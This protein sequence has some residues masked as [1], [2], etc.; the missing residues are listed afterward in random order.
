[1][2]AT[3]TRPGPAG[4]KSV[5]MFT[6]AA[7]TGQGLSI[8]HTFLSHLQPRHPTRPPR[9]SLEGED[10]LADVRDPVARG[11]AVEGVE[12]GRVVGCANAGGVGSTGVSAGKCSGMGAKEEMGGAQSE[13]RASPEAQVSL[14]ILC[15]NSEG[16]NAHCLTHRLSAMQ[17]SFRLNPWYACR[18]EAVH[19]SA[20]SICCIS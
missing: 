8:L 13:G 20:S 14:S 18:C 12:I 1:M 5:P 11:V 10:T 16:R 7:T 9:A 2:A 4:V 15:N 6:L 17:K 19:V 3:A